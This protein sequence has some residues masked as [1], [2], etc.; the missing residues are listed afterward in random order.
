MDIGKSIADLAMNIYNPAK[1]GI[2]KVSDSVMYAIK[3]LLNS[4]FPSFPAELMD[5][6][7]KIISEGD[8]SAMFP[9]IENLGI[10]PHL[11]KLVYD[12]LTKNVN[13]V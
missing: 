7:F 4:G 5:N 12:F 3:K 2:N 8:P 11:F 6:L 13:G 1:T 10:P 9:M